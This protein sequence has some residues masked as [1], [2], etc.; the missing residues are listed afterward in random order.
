MVPID[1][2]AICIAIDLIGVL[3]CLLLRYDFGADAIK[4]KTYDRKIFDLLLLLT[5]FILMADAFTW[6]LLN[7]AEYY[8]LN[9]LVTAIYYSLHILIATTWILYCDYLIYE[10]KNRI[11]KIKRIL[12]L[13]ALIVMAGAFLSYKYP[14]F[15]MITKTG[16]YYRGNYYYPFVLLCGI[17]LSYSIYIIVRQIKKNQKQDI[18]DRKLLVLIVYPLFPFIGVIIQTL[19]YGI[20]IT[21]ILTT[22]SMIIVY[23]NFQNTQLIIDPLTKIHNRYK[24]DSFLDKH[25]YDINNKSK[26]FLAIID[27]NDFKT[28]NDKFGHAK[29][30]EA[31]QKVAEIL[32]ANSL[33]T[34]FVGRIGGDEFVIFG[35]RLSMD[36]IAELVEQ[37]HA[38]ILDFNQNGQTD[39]KL[40][41]S[42]GY[43]VQ[44]RNN[45]KTKNQMIIEAD[46]N[47]YKQKRN[48]LRLS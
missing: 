33:R 18:L 20:N 43:S 2:K 35:D 29:G 9:Y 10:D 44:D 47:M 46:K 22:I 36:E 41:L 30:D 6:A 21:W 23:F 27:V 12:T 24:F 40:S 45:L 16:E 1:T 31:L 38:E 4:V 39:Y 48:K 34:D 13:P 37:I 25:F 26:K 19:Y 42:I 15:F 5:F 7:D 32:K 8:F 11:K 28:I 14:I 17:Y 3:I